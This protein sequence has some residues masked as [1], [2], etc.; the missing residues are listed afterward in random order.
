MDCSAASD[1]FKCYAPVA[2]LPIAENTF[3]FELTPFLPTKK[4]LIDLPPRFPANRGAVIS[5][6]MLESAHAAASRSN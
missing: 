2:R 1:F 5:G 6:G 4:L 3:C